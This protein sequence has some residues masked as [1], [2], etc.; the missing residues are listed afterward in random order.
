ML[1]LTYE[2]EVRDVTDPRIKRAFASYCRLCL[3]AMVKRVRCCWCN[4]HLC[5]G[6]RVR[7]FTA[8]EGYP[9][10]EGSVVTFDHDEFGWGVPTYLGCAKGVCLDERNS[11]EQTLTGTLVPKTILN[12]EIGISE[13]SLAL[14]PESVARRTSRIG[15]L[16]GDRVHVPIVEP[17]R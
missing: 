2:D 5:I 14:L 13:E 17:P 4:E 1:S 8:R 11:S 6:E 3:E 7:I 15:V 16:M 12:T 10:K 9:F